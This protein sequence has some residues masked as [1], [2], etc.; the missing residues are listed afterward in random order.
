M[1]TDYRQEETMCGI[2]G[3]INGHP[4][5]NDLVSGLQ[6]LE[7]RGYDSAGIATLESGQI[8]RV[9][10]TDRIQSL[11]ERLAASPHDGRLGIA[12]TRWATHGGP[13]K[14]NAHPHATERVALVHNGI[15]ENHRELRKAL[16]SRG[17]SFKSQTD[18][19]VILHLIDEEVRAGVEPVEA[20]RSTL[21]KLEGRYAIA[22]LFRD[23]DGMILAAKKGAPLCVGLSH[24]GAYLASDVLALAPFAKEV[25]ELEDFDVA[26]VTRTEL[27]IV[28]AEGRQVTRV[29]RKVDSEEAAEL[30]EFEDYMSKEIHEQPRAVRAAL[31][32]F[33]RSDG[34]L[35][36]PPEGRLDSSVDHIIFVACGSSRYAGLIAKTWFEQIAGIR[37]DVEVAS[38]FRYARRPLPA[39]AV[40]IAVS[41][42]GETADTLA[43]LEHVRARGQKTIAIVNVEQSTLAREADFLVPIHAGPEVGV[44][45]TKAFTAQLCVLASLALQAAKARGRLS[46][47]DERKYCEELLVLPA[48]LAAML[49]REGEIHQ[50]AKWLSKN[51][52][53]LFMGRGPSASVAL[54]GALKLK[55]VSYIH[56]EGFAAGELKHGPIALITEGTPVI[57]VCPSDELFQ[58][59]LSNVQEVQAR[60]AEV[61]LLTDPCGAEKIDRDSMRVLCVPSGDMTAQIQ[62]MMPLQLLA[63]HTARLL[64]RDVDKPRNLAKSVTVE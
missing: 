62:A 22:A 27:G 7:Y 17:C 2:F 28:D 45:S 11:R 19:E 60:G 18:S 30:G 5:A 53:A 9:R 39:N 61:L 48:V 43:A 4:V 32:P 55:E 33:L 40:C 52:T 54:E 21:S 31:R 42:S 56:A 16:Q 24:D 44:A 38:E 34:T 20:L 36:A 25:V 8:R 12:H 6:R 47:E 23:H 29:A 59:T 49:A 50:H 14:K 46:A 13:T 51:R 3:A 41:Q 15:V 37:V 63:Y 57:A 26:T 58:K 10:S 64:G 35:A 1:C